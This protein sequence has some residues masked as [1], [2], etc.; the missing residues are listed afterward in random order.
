MAT[1]IGEATI[2]LTFD[3]KELDKSADKAQSKVKSFLGTL[4]TTAKIGG[5]FLAGAFVAAG[6]A[7]SA[8]GAASVKA[9]AETEQL[10]GGVETLF[11]E[12]ADQMLKY[13][14]QAYK[15]AQISAAEFM[16]TSIQFSA[17]LVQG[18]GGDTAK[19]AD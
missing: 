8:L 7:V 13:A 6:S 3:N 10:V 14:R 2:K 5:K 11:G 15:T 18:L 4:G 9:Y 17:S 1:T 12:S 16:D 19:A